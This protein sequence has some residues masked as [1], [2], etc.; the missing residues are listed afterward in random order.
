MEEIKGRGRAANWRAVCAS[1]CSPV[2]IELFDKLYISWPMTLCRCW[3]LA[4]SFPLTKVSEVLF[5]SDWCN[6]E[7]AIGGLL[8][9]HSLLSASRS[10]LSCYAIMTH[11][12]WS[13]TLV[14][15]D[16]SKSLIFAFHNILRGIHCAGVFFVCWSRGRDVV[17]ELHHQSIVD[18]YYS[19]STATLKVLKCYF[20]VS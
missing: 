8:A 1:F 5:G 18:F 7:L 3:R 19:L 6:E 17:V 14:L 16:V 2:F 9:S 13:L 4:S 15:L 10:A 20:L 12:G 11:C